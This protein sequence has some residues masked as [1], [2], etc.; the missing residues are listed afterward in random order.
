MSE[1]TNWM[2]KTVYVT[3]I[4]STPEK[5]WTA[6]TSGEFT[7][8]YF[9][10]RRVESDWK[11]G[12]KV[13]YTMEDGTVDIFGK[14][15][16]SDHPRLLSF[17]W[18]VQW[19]DEHA[20]GMGRPLEELRRLPETLV[21]FAIDKLGEVVRLT[22]T[23]S[24]QIELDEKLLEGGRRGWPIILSGLKSLLETGRAMPPFNPMS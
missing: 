1:T 20:K 10:G 3:Y 21:T 16:R 22:M 8:Q 2:P 4:V 23:E 6:L 5:V 13:T 12:S 24:H 9:F 15:V 7:K 18:N 17:T 19:R 11:V 14:I